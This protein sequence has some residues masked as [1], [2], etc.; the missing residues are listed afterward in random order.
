MGGNSLLGRILTA[1]EQFIPDTFDNQ[2]RFEEAIQQSEA[3]Q[4]TTSLNDG[5][6]IEDV[7]DVAQPDNV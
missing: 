5:P 3:S 6:V 2:A 4:I 1:I 7:T